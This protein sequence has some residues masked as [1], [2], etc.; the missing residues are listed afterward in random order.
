MRNALESAGAP[1]PATS[2]AVPNGQPGNESTELHALLLYDIACNA[3]I[4]CEL[5]EEVIG[6]ELG[7]SSQAISGAL[8][9][10]QVIGF[11]AD[12]GLDPH[13]VNG[14][15]RGG[16]ADWLLDRQLRDALSQA[17]AARGS[18]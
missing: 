1:V 5:L 4:L 13:H 16:A 17:E 11:A 15:V 12:S 3:A 10:A 14:R 9:I 8:R 2:T 7:I 18:K 6:E